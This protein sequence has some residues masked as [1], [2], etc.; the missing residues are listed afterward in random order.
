MNQTTRTRRQGKRAATPAVLLHLPDVSEVRDCSQGI[1][2]WPTEGWF[3]TG[4]VGRG[5][6]AAAR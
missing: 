3:T 1:E 4:C 2:C 6:R 5:A